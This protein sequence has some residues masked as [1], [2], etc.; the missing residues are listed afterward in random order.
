MKDK[1]KKPYFFDK[2]KSGFS[3]EDFEQ[4]SSELFHFS[5]DTSALTNVLQNNIY[6]Y[7]SSND[8]NNTQFYYIDC[9]ILTKKELEAVHLNIF[10]EDKAE[11]YVVKQQKDSA[12]E[13]SIK[14]A[15]TTPNRII[16]LDSI[17]TNSEDEE[18]LNIINKN[19]IDSGLFWVYYSNELRKVQK[20]NVRNELVNILTELRVN[21][22]NE[23]NSNDKIPVEKRDEFVQAL[24]DRTLFIKFLEDRHIINS[25]FYGDNIV[26]KDILKKDAKEVNQLF[27]KVHSIFNNNL[28]DDPTIDDYVLTDGVLKAIINSIEGVKNGQLSLFDLKFDIIPIESISL[29]YEI[30]LDEKQRKNG[31]YYTPPQL[32]NFI[33]EKTI[34]HKGKII[35][36]ACGSG[37]FLISAYKRLLQLDNRKFEYV[38]DKINHRTKLIKD[39]IFGIEKEEIARRLS[40]F[41]LYLSILDDLT[42][43]ENHTL[44]KLLEKENNYPL[45]HENIGENIICSNTFEPNKFDNEKFDFIVGNPPWKKDFSKE[46]AFAVL[47]LKNNESDFSGKSEL[48]QLFQHKAKTWSTESTRYGFVVNTSNYTN[49]DSKFQDY[50]YRNF[51]I[52]NFYEVTNLELFT[53]SEPAIV[54]IYT[55][56]L[57]EGNKLTLNVLKSNDFTKLFKKILISEADNII[58]AQKDLINSDNQEATPLKT[59][60]VGNTG[61]NRIVEYLES[62]KFDKFENYIL[63][64]ETGK[65]FIRQG[66]TIYAKDILPKYFKIPKD[67]FSKYKASKIQELKELFHIEN[68]STDKSDAFKY[69][70]LSPKHISNFTFSF[71]DVKYYLNENIS[72]LRRKGKRENFIDKRI[73][74]PRKTDNLRACFL[75]S[76]SVENYPSEDVHTIKLNNNNY[77]LFTGILNSKLSEY[78]LKLKYWHRAKS[79]FPRINETAISQIPIPKNKN[80]EL[81]NQIDELS[82]KFT[83]GELLFENKEDE[84]NELIFNLYGLGI[85]EKQRINDFFI[86]EKEKVKTVDLINYAKEVCEYFSDFTKQGINVFYQP[87]N[88][89]NLVKGVCIVKVYFGEREN[90]YPS[91]K[92]VGR[93]LLLELIKNVSEKNILSLRERIYGKNTIYFIKDNYKSS[94]SLTKASEDA[95][96]EINKI[97]EFNTKNSNNDKR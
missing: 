53:A 84:F 41:S 34:T 54:C 10:S 6:L 25:Y 85:I 40:V 95:I 77:Y 20:T 89:Q 88:E 43:E 5:N 63:K 2:E 68:T 15:K 9:N 96:E 92:K 49:E 76:N 56:G 19:S 4:I 93:H 7:S 48:S 80:E 38:I 52:E 37:A 86:K 67:E 51:N 17:P 55:N 90:I 73:L 44:K 29:V 75:D 14:Y 31:I 62:Q 97:N 45:F 33:T 8:R 27:T 30:F 60:L 66:V 81:V 42:V 16:E 71:K 47:Y 78:F 23:I 72:N 61:D 32:T 79:G 3:I 21:L 83:K 59:L 39:N 46:D 26:Y 18:L 1:T 69:P 64:D 50:F 82:E 91:S 11:F 65:C 57:K 35:D 24:I 13:Y 12:E 28:F 22:S 70:Y 94:W 74:L 87:Y 36:S 58:I